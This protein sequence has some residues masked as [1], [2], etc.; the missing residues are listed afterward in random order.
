MVMYR[1]PTGQAAAQG[2]DSNKT[3]DLPPTYDSLFLEAAPEA[4]AAPPPPGYNMLTVNLPHSGQTQ[5]TEPP[6][7]SAEYTDGT[8][9]P[10]HSSLPASAAPL[11]RPRQSSHDGTE[12]LPGRAGGA[13]QSSLSSQM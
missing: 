9:T 11:T 7:D 5:V 13:A 2:P 12:I 8:T 4:G 10:S 3:V 1:P 6:S